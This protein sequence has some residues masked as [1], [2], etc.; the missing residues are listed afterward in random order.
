MPFLSRYAISDAY[1]LEE[2]RRSYQNSAAKG[3]IELLKELYSGKQRGESQRPPFEIALL[4]VEDAN[5]EVRQWIARHGKYLDYSDDENP[6]AARQEEAHLYDAG[7]RPIGIPSRNLEER[8]K[9]DPDPFVCASLRENPTVFGGLISS[10][11]KWMGYFREANHMERLALVRNP[12]VWEPFIEKIFDPEDNAL[13]ITL[14]E[15]QELV[16]AFLTN[17]EALAKEARAA[18]RRPTGSDNIEIDAAIMSHFGSRHF[19]QKLW[20]LASKWPRETKIQSAVYYAVPADDKTKAEVY[21]TC[22]E[23]AWRHMILAN[24]GGEDR[25]TLELGLKDTD[26]IC[27]YMAEDIK[28]RAVKTQFPDDP[29]ELFEAEGFLEPKVNFIGRRLLDIE[30][31]FRNTSKGLRNAIVILAVIY[32]LWQLLVW[33]FRQG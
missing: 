28:K 7:G 19:L 22:D 18:L 9:N 20:H 15:R 17:E 11:E 24:C 31:L 6:G 30:D 21:R 2:L 26:E 10:T 32:L 5:V 13:G 12:E 33:F 29:R 1:M 14:Q 23:P 27:R 16:L 8:L 25:E 4:A 3:R